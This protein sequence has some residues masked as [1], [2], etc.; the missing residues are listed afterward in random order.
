M[1]DEWDVLH[2]RYKEKTSSRK[3]GVP[4]YPTSH[5]ATA[6]PPPSSASHPHLATI[7]QTHDGFHRAQSTHLAS[8][9]QVPSHEHFPSQGTVTSGPHPLGVHTTLTVSHS[10]HRDAGSESGH[11]TAES[12]ADSPCSTE[13]T[14]KHN[15][16]NLDTHEHAQTEQLLV[17]QESG[18]DESRRLRSLSPLEQSIERALG[19]SRV[20]SLDES[21]E[22]DYV[23]VKPTGKREEEKKEKGGGAGGGETG[24]QVYA[25]WQFA[26]MQERLTQSCEERKFDMTKTSVYNGPPKQQEEPAETTL[27]SKASTPIPRKPIKPPIIKSRHIQDSSVSVQPGSSVSPTPSPLTSGVPPSLSKRPVPKSSSLSK[28]Q[29]EGTKKARGTTKQP[30]HL[31]KNVVEVDRVLPSQLMKPRSNAATNMLTSTEKK[32]PILPPA[33]MNRGSLATQPQFPAMKEIVEV[34]QERREFLES[35]GEFERSCSPSSHS[36]TQFS[37]SP[38][39]SPVLLPR[40]L[41]ATAAKDPHALNTSESHSTSRPLTL[42]AHIGSKAPA[43]TSTRS[44]PTSE[45]MRK[46]SLRRQR[47]DQQLIGASMHTSSASSG[48]VDGSSRCTSTSSTQSELVCTYSVKRMNDVSPLESMGES[49]ERGEGAWRGE[50]AERRKGGEA[51]SLRERDEREEN[52]YKYGIE[53]DMEGGSYVI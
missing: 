10:Q 4:I 15:Y 42:G 13:A 48:G 22:S 11:N 37:K 50:G 28:L 51:V 8:S 19:K 44:S 2:D 5:S 1:A 36:S 21:I 41:H 18:E 45:L 53:E 52:L 23:M 7:L 31:S 6:K 49:M 9:S 47:L 34:I 12:D 29:T 14:I 30:N 39:R 35:S 25:N 24:P 43:I 40:T 16:V 20:Q 38:K 27:P 3:C 46:L 32:K 17:S 26:Q 33:K